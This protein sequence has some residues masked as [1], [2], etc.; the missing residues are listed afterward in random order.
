M[1]IGIIGSGNVGTALGQGWLR[2]GHEVLFGVRDPKSAKAQKAVEHLTDIR[3]VSVDVAFDF[4]E[5]VV[6][7]TPPTA[8]LDMAELF[9]QYPDK[10]YIDTTNSIGTRPEPH[11]TA[12]HAIRHISG[13]QRV[14]K[15]FNSTGFENMRN[16]RYG[17][18]G[19]DM[20]CASDSKE[21]K[22][23]AK[24][25]SYDLGFEECYDFGGDDKVELLEKFALSWI[26]LAIM[27]GHGRNLAFKVIRR[28]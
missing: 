7:T 28:G 22:E 19:I 27:Q 1:K 4:A 26:N 12:F 9:R 16:P 21:A 8:V 18:I 25:L 23:V 5:V 24:A 15:C 10:I 20:F 14:V 17:E 3:L 2:A 6:L 11:A 13:A